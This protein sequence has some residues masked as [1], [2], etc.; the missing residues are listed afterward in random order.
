MLWSCW[1]DPTHHV[2]DQVAT[3]ET[4]VSRLLE[5]GV[6][7]RKQKR[8][9]NA[10]RADDPATSLTV[11]RI[12]RNFLERPVTLFGNLSFPWGR[13]SC[14]MNHGIFSATKA[15]TNTNTNCPNGSCVWHPRHARLSVRGCTRR[16][17]NLQPGGSRRGVPWHHPEL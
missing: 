1:T 3:E 11:T 9:V 10:G 17:F 8:K 2:H 13:H 14:V 16:G 12:T 5:A 7:Q 15:T 6:L 4:P